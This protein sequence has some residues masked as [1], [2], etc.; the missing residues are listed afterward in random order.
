MTSHISDRGCELVDRVLSL[1][2]EISEHARSSPVEAAHA[3]RLL[4]D[5]AAAGLVQVRDQ[6]EAAIE[7]VDRAL[8]AGEPGAAH[9]RHVCDDECPVVVFEAEGEA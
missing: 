1:L 7:Q 4:R 8:A 2:I 9:P 6:L 3:F 5:R